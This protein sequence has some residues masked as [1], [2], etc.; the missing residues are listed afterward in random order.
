MRGHGLAARQPSGALPGG[1]GGDRRGR[2]QPGTAGRQAP[3]V[4]DRGGPEA[5]ALAGGGHL[6][7]RRAR[8]GAQPGERQ[9]PAH[10][11]ARPAA[12]A[13]SPLAGLAAGPR[14]LQGHRAAPERPL[15]ARLREHRR[16]DLGDRA[17]ASSCSPAWPTS[18][19][20]PCR[21]PCCAAAS[22]STSSPTGARRSSTSG[23]CPTR[24]RRPSCR[25]QE[26]RWAR[27]RGQGAGDLAAGR[28]PRRPPGGSTAPCGG[29]LGP[30]GAG[31]PHLHP[32]LHRLA[33]LPR[34]GDPGLRR[35]ALQALSRRLA[36]ASRAPTSASRSP[37]STAGWRGCAAVL[38][39]YAS[40]GD[41]DD[42][43]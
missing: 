42:R 32:R 7:P 26:P 35:H 41:R 8:L 27:L 2:A 23:F 40:P 9:P 34:A 28:R 39:A 11:G 20:T 5:A 19:S 1:R 37:R 25:G 16:G 3:L 31:G 21:L 4:G 13:A 12:G 38:A 30:D 17:R 22:G 14:L 29:V 6:R 43:R 15:A 10:P 18:S 24:T 36:R 33:L